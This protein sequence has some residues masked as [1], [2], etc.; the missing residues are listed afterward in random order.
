M[1]RGLYHKYDVT[2]AE[3]GEELEGELFVLRLDRDPHAREAV[4]TYARS[5]R[6]ENKQLAEDLE[7]WVRNCEKTARRLDELEA[8]ARRAAGV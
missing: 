4:R 8:L 6:N 2:Y 7:R 1:P 3:T 5:V